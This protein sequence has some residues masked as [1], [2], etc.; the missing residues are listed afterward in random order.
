MPRPPFPNPHQYAVDQEVMRHDD[1][2]HYFGEMT[3]VVMMW[4][5]R[6]FDLGKVGRCEECFTS[7]GDV[8]DAYEQSSK[9]KCPACF[10][11]TFQGGFRAIV[12][13]P[14]IWDFDSDEKQDYEKRGY[15]QAGRA[16][17]Q[18]VA[19]LTLH[20]NDYL[21]RQDGSRWRMGPP[22]DDHIVTGFSPVGQL[23]PS[24]SIL[25]VQREDPSSIVYMIPVNQEGLQVQGWSP[26]MLYPTT[27]DVVRG[28]AADEPVSDDIL[29]A[30]GAEEDTNPTILDAG[31]A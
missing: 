18:T 17:V 1:A 27:N 16:G 10:G 7:W 29:V 22:S 2:V 25:Q 15:T 24:G 31:G 9:R 13:R 12:Y 11:T 23:I 4:N 19:G 28:Q 14:C 20:D 21:I 6:D 30:G 3:A 8:T 26:Y 5:Q